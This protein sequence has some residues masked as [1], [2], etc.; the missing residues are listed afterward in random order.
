[1]IFVGFLGAKGKINWTAC[2]QVFSLPNPKLIC[3][4][5]PHKRVKNFR[6]D[7]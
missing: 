1:M 2:W 7:Y 6:D 4:I 5:A 3:D